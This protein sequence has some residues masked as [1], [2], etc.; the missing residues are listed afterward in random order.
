GLPLLQRALASNSQDTTLRFNYGYGLWRN[1]NYAEAIPH[2]MAVVAANVKDGE[3]Q[4]LLAK[5]FAALGKTAEASQADQ[6]ARKYLG[7]YAKWEVAPDKIPFL[8]RLKFDFNRAAFY[9]LE[10][11]QA[12]VANAPKAQVRATQQSLDRTRQLITTNQLNE[13]LTE[14]QQVLTTDPTLAEA[15]LLRGQILQRRGEIDQALNSFSAATYWNPRLVAAH[16]AL[17][18]IYF[19]R[20]DRL[21]AM[22]HSK[23]ALEIDPQDR[24][25]VALKRQIETAR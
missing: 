13:A 7:N 22:T 25:A 8:S 23:Q 3:A 14:I 19:A 4:Y 10:R 24:D 21:R 2:L 16:V 11:G 6:E 12:G 17:G 15:H 18:Q 5:S 1:K 20:G 9:K